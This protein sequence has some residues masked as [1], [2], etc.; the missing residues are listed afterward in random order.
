M[1]V[2]AKWPH[3]SY[4]SNPF[5]FIKQYL[6]FEKLQLIQEASHFSCNDLTEYCIYQKW[7]KVDQMFWFSLG[8]HWKFNQ[9]FRFPSGFHWKNIPSDRCMKS[10]EASWISC[11]FSKNKYFLMK[12]K[13]FE[14]YAS[15]GYYAS[16]K[17]G[18]VVKTLS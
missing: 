5:N 10:C 18:S 3:E 4:A 11:N 12:L 6:F 2:D 1:I 13:A 14:A 9:M 17:I 15:C 7:W 8:F 16:I